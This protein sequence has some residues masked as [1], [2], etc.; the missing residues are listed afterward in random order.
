MGTE[1]QKNGIRIYNSTDIRCSGLCVPA[2]NKNVWAYDW[3]VPD[4]HHSGLLHNTGQ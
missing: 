1:E 2:S 4:I 3:S